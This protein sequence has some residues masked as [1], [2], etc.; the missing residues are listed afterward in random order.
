MQAQVGDELTVTGSHQGNEDRQGEIIEI[1]GAD[2]APPYLVRWR[3]GFESLFFI[4]PRPGSA[5]AQDR[6]PDTR[7]HALL[8]H[9]PSSDGTGGAPSALALVWA[10]RRRHRRCLDRWQPQIR[11]GRTHVGPFGVRT[12]APG[13]RSGRPCRRRSCE[14][15]VDI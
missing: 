9:R 13:R 7:G 6:A 14:P 12:K 4:R 3:D 15:S 1:I 10:G 5:T 2:G 8:I 11:P